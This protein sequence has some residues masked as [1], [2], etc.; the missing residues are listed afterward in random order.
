[1]QTPRF[2]VTAIGEVMLRYS[3]PVGERLERAQ[4][5]A[6]H[7]GGAEA[8]MLGGLSCLGRR[9]AWVSGLPNNPLGRIIT[10]HLQLAKVN[11]DGVVWFDE[12]RVGT[13]YLEFATPP[14]ATQV[15]YDRANSC[16]ARLASTQIDWDFLL[17]TRLLHLTGITPPLSASCLALTQE[18]IARAKDAR[19]PISFDVNFRGKLWTPA[20]AAAVIKPMIQGIDLLF[21][22]QGDAKLLFGCSGTPQEIVHAMVEL[23]NAKQVVVSVG[24]EGVFAWDGQTLHHSPGRPVE[25]IDRL[26]AGDAMAAGIIHGWLDGDLVRGLD[27]GQVM[28]A[29][30]LSMHGDMVISTRDEVESLLAGSMGSLNR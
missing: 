21:C 11:T 23:S 14:R 15:Y 26:G 19:V 18:A 22:G 16:A 8:N 6:I 20:Q 5:L 12:G 29:L 3:V 28:A 17:D 25:I 10:N 2:D 30:C 13:Y 24:D 7:P 1:M 4:Q 9:C 27:Y